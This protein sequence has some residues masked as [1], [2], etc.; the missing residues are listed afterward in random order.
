MVRPGDNL[1]ARQCQGVSDRDPAAQADAVG[2]IHG[3]VVQD[4][5]RQGRAGSGAAEGHARCAAT[6][7]T[8][9]ANGK[10]AIKRQRVGANRKRAAGQSKR[11][12]GGRCATQCER[13]RAID[14]QIAV[15]DSRHDGA[16]H[17]CVIDGR[18]LRREGAVDD[19]RR[20]GAGQSDGGG[21]SMKRCRAHGQHAGNRDV[22]QGCEIVSGGVSGNGEVEVVTSRDVIATVGSA[23]VKNGGDRGNKSP[24]GAAHDKRRAGS[25]QRERL[26]RTIKRCSRSH[27]QHGRATPTCPYYDVA[28]RGERLPGTVKR[29]VIV[30][31][32]GDVG[33]GD[34]GVGD[35]RGGGRKG[36]GHDERRACAGEGDGK[37]RAV[38]GSRLDREHGCHRQIGRRRGGAARFVDRQIVERCRGRAADGGTAAGGVGNGL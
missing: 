19:E 12:A 23:V 10:A 29:Q 17:A 11:A 24:V 28:S 5:R 30:G 22:A 36:T 25:I 14:C 21:R 31:R 26:V 35:G 18:I 20:D 3:Q 8:A 34:A 27:G 1:A 38:K 6:N 9:A 32:P 15:G 7:Q 33:A 16:G 37:G 4:D 2:P 13:P